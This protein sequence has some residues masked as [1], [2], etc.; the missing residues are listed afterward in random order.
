M[1]R[2]LSRIKKCNV[3]FK[4]SESIYSSGK[5]RLRIP[6]FVNQIYHHHKNTSSVPPHPFPPNRLWYACQLYWKIKNRLNTED[7]LSQTYYYTIYFANKPVFITCCED[8]SF[9]II[10][11]LSRDGQKSVFDTNIII[12]YTHL[13]M[14]IYRNNANSEKDEVKNLIGLKCNSVLLKTTYYYKLYRQK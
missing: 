10:L 2:I 9:K 12:L 13:H 1:H 7:S 4:I 14:I 3:P 5:I 11:N 8:C 6:L